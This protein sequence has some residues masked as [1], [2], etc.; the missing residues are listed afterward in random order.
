MES[1]LPDLRTYLDRLRGRRDLAVIDAPVDPY[2][3]A[4]EIHRRV[5]AAGG[6]ALLF[7]NLIG[8]DRT[9]VTNLFG[10]AERVEMA[11]GERPKQ[12]V[13]R[14]AALPHEMMP[15][16]L[17]RVWKQRDLAKPL[18]KL[19]QRRTRKPA[20]TELREV[21]PRA[22]RMPLLTTWQEDGGPFVTLPLVY[23]EHP[24]GT[25]AP[26]LGM[27]RMQRYDDEHFGLHWQIGKGGG[28]HHQIAESR[29]QALPVNL[30][31]GGPPALI[32][33]AIAP[34][35]ENV[36]ELMLAS[37]LAGE[38]LAMADNPLGPLPLVANCEYVVVGEA[39]PNERRPEGPFGDHYGYYSLR[40]R[41]PGHS[42]CHAEWLRRRDAVLPRHGGGQASPG[43]LL[44][45]RLSCRNCSR[46]SSR[47]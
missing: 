34:L 16:T 25:G 5:I 15:P 22:T 9:T 45:R 20:V 39:L 4:A 10:T 17:D 42:R 40:T 2:L 26:N 35:P 27:Y 44:H 12:L 32:L 11:F 24:D 36:P 7:R 28:F 43:G 3:E 38:R 1:S 21:P 19:G 33:S 30:F 41:L 14:I 13:E 47:W 23:T 46:R 18:L 6:P 29:G 31:L 37:L 8:H